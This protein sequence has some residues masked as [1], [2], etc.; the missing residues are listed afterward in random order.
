MISAP[1]LIAIGLLWSIYIGLLA[2]TL[3]RHRGTSEFRGAV[4]GMFFLACVAFTFSGVDVEQAADS[5]F[6]GL[7]VSIYIKYFTLTY[8]VYLH[9]S[10]LHKVK[11]FSAGMFRAMNWLNRTALAAG[12]ISFALLVVFDLYDHPDLRY[13]VNAGRDLIVALYMLVILIPSNLSLFKAEAVP[14][15]RVKFALNT[16]FC[17]TYVLVALSSLISLVV[18]LFDLTDINLLLPI[19][20]PLT[21]LVYGLFVLAL[22][23]HRWISFLLFPVRLYTY[24]RLQ[25]VR[26]EVQRLT[27]IRLDFDLFPAHLSSPAELEFAIYQTVIF[28]L[29]HAELIPANA[30]QN[31]LA[32]RLAQFLQVE[33]PYP[34]L[35]RGLVRLAD[36]RP[37]S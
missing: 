18:V 15:M 29:D 6:N 36:D 20:L 19:F 32:N 12:G 13:Y 28:I 27:Q 21:Y 25:R 3:I 8:G 10:L 26:R 22:L 5:A 37:R 34:M 35:V 23:P 2:R 24:W 17:A 7:P 33:R 30:D 9:C 14:T 11:P 1:K 31:Y 4:W 16:L